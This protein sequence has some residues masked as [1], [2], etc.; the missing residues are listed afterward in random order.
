M[1]KMR[2]QGFTLIEL[3]VVMIIIGI[4]AG[5]AV[6][7]LKGSDTGAKTSVMKSDARQAISAANTYYSQELSYSN[8]DAT[9]G[10][11]AVATLGTSSVQVSSS[12]DDTITIAASDCGTGAG[13]GFTISVANATLANASV[14]YDSCNDATPIY[15]AP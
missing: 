7:K 9:V 10:S 12:K 2:K 6:A 4:L 3:V 11:N 13:S 1:K 5:T 15:T 14:T 8:I